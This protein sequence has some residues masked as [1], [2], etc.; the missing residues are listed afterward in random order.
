MVEAKENWQWLK[1]LFILFSP[2]I[3]WVSE[4]ASNL[5]NVSGGLELQWGHVSGGI[6]WVSH[7]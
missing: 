3:D 5:R 1:M 4:V 6:Q 2:L 7:V